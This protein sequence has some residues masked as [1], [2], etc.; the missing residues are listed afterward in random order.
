VTS[1][2]DR[3]RPPR[4]TDKRGAAAYLGTTERH[5]K[6]L[7]YERALAHVH[8]GGKLMF[9]YGDLDRFIKNNRTEAAS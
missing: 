3:Y 5:I 7:V 2:I 8:I 1:P 9:D 6:T 4:L